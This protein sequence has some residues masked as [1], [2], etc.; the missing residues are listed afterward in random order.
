MFDATEDSPVCPQTGLIYGRIPL[1]LK[2]MSEDCIYLNIYVPYKF[3]P[4]YPWPTKGSGLPILIFIHG[5]AFQS[6][7]G[8]TDSLGPEYLLTKDIVVIT[9]NYR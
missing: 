6:G 2:G 1:H 9:F 7:G 3:M 4:R 8:I 5:G